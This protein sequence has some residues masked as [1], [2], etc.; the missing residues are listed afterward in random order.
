[1]SR[2]TDQRYEI[3]CGAPQ[4]IQSLQDISDYMTNLGVAR[5]S[6]EIC[7]ESSYKIRKGQFGKGVSRIDRWKDLNRQG[8][9]K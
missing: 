9:G 1:M 7:L 2:L 5:I 6:I 8:L 3:G 4:S